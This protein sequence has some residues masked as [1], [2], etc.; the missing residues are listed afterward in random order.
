[1]LD[2]LPRGDSVARGGVVRRSGLLPHRPLLPNGTNFWF[3]RC[4]PGHYPNSLPGVKKKN[5]R[6]KPQSSDAAG[7]WSKVSRITP[8]ILGTAASGAAMDLTTA[9]TDFQQ[10]KVMAG[11]QTR[12]ARKMLDMQEFQGAAVLKLIEA[13]GASAAKAGDVMVAAATGLGCEIDVRG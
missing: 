6:E 1:M 10:S 4:L 2:L 3:G 7:G 5:L 13:A 8:P 9:L 12:V 11:V